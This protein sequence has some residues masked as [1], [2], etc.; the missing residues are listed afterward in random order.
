MT[1][2]TRRHTLS[3]G[4]VQIHALKPSALCICFLLQYKQITPVTSSQLLIQAFKPRNA[5]TRPDVRAAADAGKQGQT[6]VQPLMQAHAQ[7]SIRAVTCRHTLSSPRFET[8]RDTQAYAQPSIR[9]VTYRHMLS[10]GHVQIHA[11]KPSALSI[12]LLLQHK[13]TIPVMHTQLLIQACKPM[14]AGTRP[15]VR[16]AADAGKQVQTRVQPL[17]QANKPRCTA[18][19]SNRQACAHTRSAV[20]ADKQ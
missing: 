18:H 7:R 9:A 12:C 17:M 10:S 3:S 8:D 1:H 13:Q 16:A 19:P 5:G 20:D 15:D 4:H 11:L 6:R 14:N 2:H